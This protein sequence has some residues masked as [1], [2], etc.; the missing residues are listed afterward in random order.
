MRSPSVIRCS[1]STPTTPC[2]RRA[3]ATPRWWCRARRGAPPPPRPPP[4]RRALRRAGPRARAA[5]SEERARGETR[6]VVTRAPRALL[7]APFMAG[8][9]SIGFLY[10]DRRADQPWSEGDL[11]LAGALAAVAALHR[12]GGA[13]AA[14]NAAAAPP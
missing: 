8:E 2:W 4:P 12:L 5:S 14:P 6:S 7:V 11:A 10:L 13:L 1:C 9:V 3:T